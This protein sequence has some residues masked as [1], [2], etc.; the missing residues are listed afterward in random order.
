MS[1]KPGTEGRNEVMVHRPS[2]LRAE[3]E[4]E[5]MFLLL[6]RGHGEEAALGLAVASVLRLAGDVPMSVATK[7]EVVFGWLP[8]EEWWRVEGVFKA[9]GTPMPEPLTGA[10]ILVAVKDGEI[11]G[12]HV[13]QMLWHV[14]PLWVAPAEQGT[15]LW[16]ELS[17]RM[18]ESFHG[19]GGTAFYSFCDDE[20]TAYMLREF[21]CEEIPGRTVFIKKVED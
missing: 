21:G 17:S 15:N 12:F 13:R 14:E 4:E 8:P 5:G 1:A 9:Q 2:G 16:R 19:L 20:K 18:E 11:V 10:A 7:Q 6:L 3:S